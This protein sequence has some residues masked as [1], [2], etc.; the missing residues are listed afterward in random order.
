MGNAGKID[1]P[2]KYEPYVFTVTF[3]DKYG[4]VQTIQVNDDELIVLPKDPT[5][6]GYTFL[7]WH[8]DAGGTQ[9]FDHMAPIQADMQVYAAW[10]QNPVD[11][12]VKAKVKDDTKTDAV[13]ERLPQ[14]SD[15]HTAPFALAL[16]L[17]GAGLIAARHHL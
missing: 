3:N 9:A 13:T 1:V 7:G 2:F 4:K 5:K 8:L 11:T 12:N 16:A 17:L 14:T 6:V 10:A 15:E